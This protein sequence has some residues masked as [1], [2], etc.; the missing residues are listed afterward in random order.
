[1]EAPNFVANGNI[2]MCRFVKV[3]TSGNQ[4]VLQA[5]SNVDVVGIAQNFSDYAP[6]PSVAT[7]YAAVA[8]EVIKVA[9][10]GEQALLEIG[11]GGC[12]AGDYLVSD[13]NGKG[14]SAAT[15]GPTA[16]FVGA[17]TFVTAN[18]GDIIRVIVKRIPKYYPA[19]S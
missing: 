18:A 9:G 3:D 11:S 7:Q 4:K 14:V 2:T 17:Q 16:Q 15:T 8:G 1:M 13:T 6:I 5:G 12:T 10:D 19:L